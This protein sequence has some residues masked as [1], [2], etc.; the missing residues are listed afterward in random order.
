MKRFHR[1]RKLKKDDYVASFSIFHVSLIVKK[2][3]IRELQKEFVLMARSMVKGQQ[4]LKGLLESEG[5]DAAM[6]CAEWL[7]KMDMRRNAQ[8]V[9]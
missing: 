8:F 2:I 5:K 7:A 4:I 3:S 1:W 6:E 9:Y